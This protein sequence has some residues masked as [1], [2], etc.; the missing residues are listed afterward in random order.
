MLSEFKTLKA[1][2][3]FVQVSFIINPNCQS[4]ALEDQ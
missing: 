4:E 3:L 1:F 2:F